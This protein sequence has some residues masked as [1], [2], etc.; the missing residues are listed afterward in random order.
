MAY[1]GAVNENTPLYRLLTAALEFEY[2]SFD[3]LQ[4]S[5]SVTN[6]FDSRILPSQLTDELLATHDFF[7]LTDVQAEN[8]TFSPDTPP[9]V[10]ELRR[11]QL[12]LGQT[13]N[14]DD[15]RVSVLSGKD[16]NE[17]ETEL[18]K[19]SKPALFSY[20]A[21][22]LAFPSGSTSKLEARVILLA[23]LDTW[24]LNPTGL[25]PRFGKSLFLFTSLLL[26]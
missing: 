8:I 21:K 20:I 13:A 22:K 19:H 11:K 15:V 17:L 1:N 16:L 14:T 7:P 5:M 10:A 12:R 2:S 26:I 24:K 25:L 9:R 23:L 6:T 18:V 3:F 4:G